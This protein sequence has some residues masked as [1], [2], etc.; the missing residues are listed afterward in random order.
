MLMRGICHLS[1]IPVRSNPGSR[2]E[3]VT[4]LLLGETYQ[5]LKIEEDWYQIL[6]EQDHYIG[7]ISSNQFCLFNENSPEP[8]HTLKHYPYTELLVNGTVV[9]A[10]PGSQIAL[11]E[12]FYYF[13]GQQC[14]LNPLPSSLNESIIDFAKQFLNTPYLWG[15]KGIMGIDCSGFSSI[16]FACYGIKIPRDAAEQ[17][18]IGKSIAFVNEI[19]PADLVFFENKEGKIT[20]VGIAIDQDHIIHASGAVR[21]DLLDSYGIFNNSTGKHTHTLKCIKRLL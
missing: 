3:M 7:W 18:L 15:G 17:A 16:V 21:I 11:K 19:Q 9:F 2:S 4:Q 6:N 1:L 8:N 13:N 20:H 10:T 5:V 14:E 12:G